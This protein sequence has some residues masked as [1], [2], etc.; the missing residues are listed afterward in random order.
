MRTGCVKAFSALGFRHGSATHVPGVWAYYDVA[1]G[2][3]SAL[4]PFIG[5][6]PW[7][8]GSTMSQGAMKWQQSVDKM[9]RAAP[10]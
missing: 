6:I 9:R 1:A 7:M 10:G 8:T 5:L 4:P 3:L 2:A